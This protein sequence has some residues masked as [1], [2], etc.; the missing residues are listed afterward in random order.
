[1]EERCACCRLQMD[2]ACDLSVL[3]ESGRSQDEFRPDSEV[4]DEM[5]K[6]GY[7]SLARAV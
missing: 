5:S 1:V 3:M 7:S 2:L 4:V 6:I